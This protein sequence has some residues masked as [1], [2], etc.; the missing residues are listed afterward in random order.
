MLSELPPAPLPGRQRSRSRTFSEAVQDEQLP[1]ALDPHITPHELRAEVRS[2]PPPHTELSCAV[3]DSPMRADGV[4]AVAAPSFPLPADL[5]PRFTHSHS[6]NSR[7]S[8]HPAAPQSPQRPP[9]VTHRPRRRR[10]GNPHPTHLLLRPSHST[11]LRPSPPPPPRP[12]RLPAPLLPVLSSPRR[13]CG[14]AFLPRSLLATRFSPPRTRSPRVQSLHSRTDPTRQPRPSRQ[15]R[16]RRGRLRIRLRQDRSQTEY[17]A[18]RVHSWPRRW[19]RRTRYRPRR[20][21]TKYGRTSLSWRTQFR[22][23]DHQGFATIGRASWF[24]PSLLLSRNVA[25][26]DTTTARAES[27]GFTDGEGEGERLGR[28]LRRSLSLNPTHLAAGQSPHRAPFDQLELIFSDD[29]RR[30]RSSTLD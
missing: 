15:L 10:N 1:T 12:P 5:R 18:R 7:H 30:R 4:A 6:P 14:R 2:L 28:V 26:S 23:I 8:D 19:S 22:R 27:E 21:E 20:T 13:R 16:R 9:Q 11:P 3:T 25:D 29:S 24:V 17:S